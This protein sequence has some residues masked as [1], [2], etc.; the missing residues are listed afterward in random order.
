MRFTGPELGFSG[1]Q[2]EDDPDPNVEFN[3]NTAKLSFS[4]LAHSGLAQ[5]YQFSEDEKTGI[6]DNGGWEG[7][8]YRHLFDSGAT[9]EAVFYSNEG[10]YEPGP[11][12]WWKYDEERKTPPYLGSAGRPG[13]LLIG[14]GSTAQNE[15]I[16]IPRF[17][18]RE[19]VAAFAQPNNNFI[20]DGS[21]HGVRGLYYCLSNAGSSCALRVTGGAVRLGH[22]NASNVFTEAGLTSPLGRWFFEPTDR[23]DRV[24]GTPDQEWNLYGWWLYKPADGGDYVAAA[25]AF[26]TV[27]H[28][29]PNLQPLSGTATYSGGAAGLYAIV[30][31]NEG[32]DAGSFTA[33]AQLTLDFDRNRVSGRIDRF[34]GADGRSRDWSV[35]LLEQGFSDQGGIY[36]DGAGGGSAGKT[37]WT[38]DGHGFDDGGGKWSGYVYYDDSNSSRPLR[39]P[40]PPG[41]PTV[42]TG[43]FTAV[44]GAVGRMVGGFGVDRE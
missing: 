36:G 33:R 7:N 18:D 6:P 24:T 20:L 41:K 27:N 30:R 12:F 4:G 14:N 17:G 42:A 25:G 43:T 1:V 44:H 3:V 28:P 31:G 37:K 34:T 38:I 16:S 13:Q 8:R 21:Y 32:V 9:V 22:V 40:A 11:A 19:G 39:D 35:E 5:K 15:R 10:G 29:E 23:N 26:D 2:F